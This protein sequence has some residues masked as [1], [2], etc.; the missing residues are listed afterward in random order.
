MIVRDCR[1]ISAEYS[2]A[3]ADNGLIFAS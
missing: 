2:L 1:D 3:V